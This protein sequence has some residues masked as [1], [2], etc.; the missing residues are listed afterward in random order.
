[1]GSDLPEKGLVLLSSWP[2]MFGIRGV[3][4][5]EEKGLEYEY[6]E[7]DLGNKKGPVLV[8]DG[9]PI[10]ESLIIL[11]Y[12]DETWPGADGAPCFLPAD[13]FAR[14]QARFWADFIDKKITDAGANLWMTKGEAQ[15]EAKKEFM[16]SLKLLEG[17]LGEKP[18]FGGET[19]GFVDIALVCF[20]SWFHTYDVSGS[21]NMEAELPKLMAWVKRCQERESVSK[22]LPDPLKVYDF[23]LILKKRYGI[24]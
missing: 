8:H 21:L 7:E 22:A 9:R 14:S 5:L 12:I 17:E 13:P 16:E 2:S 18:Y 10:C 23:M 20:A 6:R 24:E 11:Q 3:I 19:F 1:M 15:A 4:A